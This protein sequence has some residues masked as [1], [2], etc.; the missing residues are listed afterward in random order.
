VMAAKF[1]HDERG[2]AHGGQVDEL[3]PG[4]GGRVVSGVPD[5]VVEDPCS[6]VDLRGH[7]VERCDQRHQVGDHQARES[8]VDD[9]QAVKL[10]VRIFTGARSLPAPATT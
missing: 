10:P 3:R 7:H 6:A 5:Q 1:D 8:T 4:P 2:R 9:A